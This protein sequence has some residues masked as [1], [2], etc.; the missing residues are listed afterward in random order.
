MSTFI[1]QPDQYPPSHPFRQMTSGGPFTTYTVTC[2]KTGSLVVCAN[3]P[4]FDSQRAARLAITRLLNPNNSNLARHH[5]PTNT[6]VFNYNKNFKEALPLTRN[7]FEI[8]R[9]TYTPGPK[10][11][12]P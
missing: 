1:A 12:A 2:L 11:P 3:S 7:D 8:H 4:F 6:L 10:E 5:V 9:V